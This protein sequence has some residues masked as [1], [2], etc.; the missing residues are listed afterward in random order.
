MRRVSVRTRL[1]N[2]SLLKAPRHATS[3]LNNWNAPKLSLLVAPHKITSPFRGFA[4]YVRFATFLINNL[5]KL[6]TLPQLQR[7]YLKTYEE[8]GVDAAIDVLKD[9]LKVCVHIV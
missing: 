2:Q 9:M 3:N 7:L 6:K 1:P 5:Q 8:K 4:S